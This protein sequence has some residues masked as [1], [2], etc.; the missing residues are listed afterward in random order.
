M[1]ELRKDLD[2]RKMITEPPQTWMRLGEL[3]NWCQANGVTRRATRKLIDEGVIEAAPW[4][5][6]RWK[7]YNADQVRRDVLEKETIRCGNNSKRQ[8]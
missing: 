1:S 6:D 2:Y 5:H 7:F 3:L 4:S 8:H